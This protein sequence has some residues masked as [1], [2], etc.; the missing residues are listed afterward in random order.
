MDRP[1]AAFVLCVLS[2][3][4]I[5]INSVFLGFLA[6]I[7]PSV[8]QNLI[9]QFAPEIGWWISAK[10]VASLIG[11]LLYTLMAVGVI[12]SVIIL[13][14]SMMFYIYPNNT[15]CIGTIILILAILSIF[16][17]GGFFIGFILGLVG[18]AL[19]ATWKPKPTKAIAKIEETTKI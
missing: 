16:I 6:A 13:L 19:G 12:F 7:M 10:P 1:S 17:G 2:G 15:R 14:G 4:F 8:F 5:L 18:G 9:G 3:I 11:V